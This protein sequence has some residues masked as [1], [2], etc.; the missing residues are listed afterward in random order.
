MEVLIIC[1]KQGLK[2]FADYFSDNPLYSSTVFCRRFCM[3]HPLFLCIVEVLGQ[4]SEYFTEMLDSVN[5]Q[6]LTPLQKCTAAIRHQ[7]VNGSAANH[8]DEY[9]KI[10]EITALDVIKLFNYRRCYSCFW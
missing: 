9:M 8:I 10:G 7:L 6:G 5:R 4:R 2:L 3:P 1:P